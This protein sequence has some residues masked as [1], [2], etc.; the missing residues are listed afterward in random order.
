M[1]RRQTEDRAERWRWS[2]NRWRKT[3]ELKID[4]E[5]RRNLISRLTLWARDPDS[6]G[7]RQKEV[8]TVDVHYRTKLQLTKS[9]EKQTLREELSLHALGEDGRLVVAVGHSDA[10]G[11]GSGA[12]GCTR[13][14]G[15]HHKLIDVIGPFVVQATGGT[16]HASW[17][18]V[19]VSAGNKV[20]ELR[21]YAGVAVSG[22]D[23]GEK[24]KDRQK[25]GEEFG[26]MR[27]V[28]AE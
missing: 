9:V 15:N 26:S 10:N 7:V 16:D 5:L 23:W 18:D 27:K 12:W 3:D 1:W 25:D 17:C 22:E 19:K 4:Y 11:G 6:R 21:V 13:I 20:R 8:L 14:H 24:E 28:N 2:E